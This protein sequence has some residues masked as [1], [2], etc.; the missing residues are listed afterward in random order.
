MQSNNSLSFKGKPVIPY[1][2]DSPYQDDFHVTTSQIY[3]RK[4]LELVEQGLDDDAI[5]AQFAN[6]RNLSEPELEEYK[7]FLGELKD[8]IKKTD[9]A[10]KKIIP[11]IFPK[12]YYRGVYSTAENRCTKSVLNAQKGDIIKPDLGYPFATS[13]KSY[14]EGYASNT[15]GEKSPEKSIVME[16]KT[17]PG[18]RLARDLEYSSKIPFK[19]D[20]VV[21][22]RGVS[23]E[24]LDKEE[25]DGITYIKLKYL[26][27][28][29]LK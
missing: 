3:I 21:F 23:Y 2:L 12:T 13:N 7:N 11:M 15:K 18:V 16:I 24:V 19:E 14:A 26:E 6:G 20:V 9:E 17:P 8:R 10:F 25:K 1:R 29:G 22:P 27:A 5:V 4:F 28:D